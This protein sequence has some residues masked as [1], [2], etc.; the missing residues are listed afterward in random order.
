M[1]PY[2][3]E[4]TGLY[5]DSRPKF[6]RAIMRRLGVD[7]THKINFPEFSRMLKPSVPD[8]VL[9]AFGQQLDQNRLQSIFHMQNELTKSI[10]DA[11]RGFYSLGPLLSFKHTN[12]RKQSVNKR[13]LQNNREN[14][15]QG[16]TNY[17]CN[18]SPFSEPNHTNLNKNHSF[19]Q[20]TS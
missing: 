9:R 16:S 10:R 1:N 15:L 4:G 19:L 14:K 17:S 12:V 13:Q 6:Y 18:Q 8:N 3:I 2:S 5:Y 11:E 7:S 20:F